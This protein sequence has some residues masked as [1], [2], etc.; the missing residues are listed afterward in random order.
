MKQRV[1]LD[2]NA[3]APLLPQARAAMLDA[4]DAGGNASSV[5]AEG[6]AARAVVE[7]AR[8]SVAA[9]TGAAPAHVVFTSGA[10]EAA[11]MVLSPDYRMGK[12]PLQVGR[13]Y[14]SA[15]EHP[16]VREGGRFAAAARVELPVGRDGRLDLAALETAL[17]AHPADAGMPLVAVMLVNNETGILQPVAE[18]AAII[19]RHGGLLVVDAVQAVGRIPVDINALGADFLI[20]SAHKIGG[21]KGI[22]ALIS[23]GE[24]L[25]PAPLITGG[26]QEKGHRCGTENVAAIA[27]FG[28]AAAVMLQDPDARNGAIAALRDRLEAGMRAIAADVVIH[29][30]EGPRV[31]NTCYFSL[32]DMKAETGQIAFDLEGVALSAGAACSS[33]KVGQSHVLTAM[34]LDPALGGLRISLGP[35]T[36]DDD[37]DAALGAFARICARRRAKG[38]AA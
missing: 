32:A 38:A 33:G 14:H 1:Y 3:T 28:A 18:A 22:G 13:L 7:A 10:T 16:C 11:N 30:S 36:T 19:H 25:M 26:G 8:R 37:I 20:L 4:L 9:L 34:G 31:G 12:A 23:R 27:G 35:S 6:R 21:P 2:W 5:H 29:G 15:I 24:T 17:S